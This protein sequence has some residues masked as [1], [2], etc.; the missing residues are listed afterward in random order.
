MNSPAHQDL[1]TSLGFEAADEI[2]KSSKKKKVAYNIEVIL[3]L[4][5]FLIF[6][7]MLRNTG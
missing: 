6:T 2:A 4:S 3:L 1:D 5:S 7:G